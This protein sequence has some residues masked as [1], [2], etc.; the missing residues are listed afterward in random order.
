[1]FLMLN[2]AT[3][4]GLNCIK[5]LGV[6]FTPRKPLKGGS[7]ACSAKSGLLK[8][9]KSYF[10]LKISVSYIKSGC[11]FTGG[12][13]LSPIYLRKSI[14]YIDTIIIAML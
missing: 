14:K 3:A 6:F 8:G 12:K 1:M 13:L 10:I 2:I 11:S 4:P 5:I 9:S 7:S